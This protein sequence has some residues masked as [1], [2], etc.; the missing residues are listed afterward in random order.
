MVLV[1]KITLTLQIFSG[2]SQGWSTGCLGFIFGSVLRGW[3][4]PWFGLHCVLIRY[5]QQAPVSLEPEA[6]SACEVN[7]FDKCFALFLF[8][9]NQ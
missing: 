9:L 8:V 1:L 7:N 2:T 4:G 3:A 5:L 6:A